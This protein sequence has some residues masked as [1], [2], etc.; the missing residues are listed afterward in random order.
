ME[1]RAARIFGLSYTATVSD[2]KSRG[3]PACQKEQKK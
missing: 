2:I 1:F 3:Q